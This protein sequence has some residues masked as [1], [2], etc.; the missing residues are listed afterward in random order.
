MLLD[1][2]HSFGTGSGYVLEILHQ[3]GERVKIKSQKVLWA[4]SYACKSYK[5][6]IGQ[7]VFLLAPNPEQD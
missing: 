7:R 5:K 1:E 6:K 2:V 4:K 3:C